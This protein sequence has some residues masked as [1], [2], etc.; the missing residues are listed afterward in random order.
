MFT[1]RAV[2]IRPFV[3]PEY[4]A[5][6]QMLKLAGIVP[7]GNSTSDS[8]PPPTYSTSLAAPFPLA[9]PRVIVPTERTL[10][11]PFP[12]TSSHWPAADASHD[13]AV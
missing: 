9:R 1:S 8:V 4:R 12:D 10:C 5:T 6:E 7:G 11:L 13:V 3:A 2:T